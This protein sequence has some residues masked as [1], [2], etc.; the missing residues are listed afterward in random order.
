MFGLLSSVVAVTW[1][2]QAERRALQCVADFSI[3]PVQCLQTP[4][5]LHPASLPRLLQAVAYQLSQA[6]ASR[7]TEIAGWASSGAHGVLSRLLE[8]ARASPGSANAP[9]PALPVLLRFL[10]NPKQAGNERHSH[11]GGQALLGWWSEN[12]NT[13]LFSASAVCAALTCFLGFKTGSVFSDK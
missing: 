11:N 6:V 10:E 13:S 8:S 1:Q 7:W 9:G 3:C 5:T 2:F 4:A 12:T